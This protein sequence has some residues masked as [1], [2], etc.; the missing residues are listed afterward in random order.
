MADAEPKIIRDQQ[1]NSGLIDTG[2]WT[3]TRKGV[4]AKNNNNTPKYPAD[5]DHPNGPTVDGAT[6]KVS[7][8]HLKYYGAVVTSELGSI[9]RE[10]G[11]EGTII[12]D[13]NSLE[14][15]EV[16]DTSGNF[17]FLGA[18][19]AISNYGGYRLNNFA[20][21]NNTITYT[22]DTTNTG[23]IYGGALANM[24]DDDNIQQLNNN[25]DLVNTHPFKTQH[26]L[27][28][29]TFTSNTAS[30]TNANVIACGGA[31]ANLGYT[32]YVKDATFT[33][34]S[35]DLGGALYNDSTYILNLLGTFTFNGNTAT[36]GGAIYNTA[37]S[38]VQFQDTLTLQT[39]SDTIANYGALV[40]NLD[41]IDVTA[42]LNGYSYITNNGTLEILVDPT[43]SSSYTLATG[44]E[45]GE[46][47][48]ADAK[49]TFVLTGHNNER[50]DISIGETKKYGIYQYTLTLKDTDE[51]AGNNNAELVL[52][53]VCDSTFQVTSDNSPFEVTEKTLWENNTNGA[54][55][56]LESG[57]LKQ[58]L[59]STEVTFS[60]NSRANDNG[61][62]LFNSG[63]VTLTNATFVNNT[64]IDGPGGNAKWGGGAI[65]NNINATL[66]VSN[67]T[68]DNNKVT[69]GGNSAGGAVINWGN[70]TFE[71][72]TFTNQASDQNQKGSAVYNNTPYPTDY[73]AGNGQITFTECTFTGNNS[74]NGNGEGLVNDDGGY[75]VF[76]DCT[77]TNN[78]NCL[79][80]SSNGTIH[81]H[82]TNTFEGNTKN[83]LN[84]YGNSTDG[85]RLK[86][87]ILFDGVINLNT[88][89][90]ILHNQ[91]GYIF[92]DLSTT[93]HS[94][95]ING[96]K[97]VDNNKYAG[98]TETRWVAQHGLYIQLDSA[99]ANQEAKY[100]LGTDCETT[101]AESKQYYILTPGL[102]GDASNKT[103]SMNLQDGSVCLHA[104]DYDNAVF[105]AYQGGMARVVLNDDTHEL[106]LWTKKVSAF[107]V[108]NT[109]T[110]DSTE[111][112]RYA[113]APYEARVNT[114]LILFN[115]FAG[116]KA[117]ATHADDVVAVAGGTFDSDLYG[118]GVKLDFIGTATGTDVNTVRQVIAGS[119]NAASTSGNFLKVSKNLSATALIGGD[120]FLNTYTQSSALERN[121]VNDKITI[122]TDSSLN[123]TWLVGG[124]FLYSAD[125]GAN[126]YSFA[127][128][129]GAGSTITVAGEA[130]V[131]AKNVVGGSVVG[132]TSGKSFLTDDSTT[133]L[134]LNA[135]TYTKVYGAGYLQKSELAGLTK[136]G[137]VNITINGGTYT[138]IYGG[139][140]ASKL[141]YLSAATMTG[142]VNITVNA[143]SAISVVSIFGGN[144]GN[145]S[146]T[147]TTKA[148]ITFTGNGSNLTFSKDNGIIGGSHATDVETAKNLAGSNNSLVFAGFNG[149]FAAPNVQDFN[150][151]KVI[152][153]QQGTDP[154]VE[155][156]SAV[157]FTKE[158]DLKDVSDWTFESGCSLT[159]QNGTNDFTGDT[160]NF[161]GFSSLEV[162][163]SVAVFIGS[164][165]TLTGWDATTTSVNFDGVAAAD[166]SKFSL[167]SS[168]N[169]LFVTRLA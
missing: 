169:K 59:S 32:Q 58:D 70:A 165:D 160:L 158:L 44:V 82:G 123:T 109:W 49:K 116:A 41:G 23:K 60:G 89:L 19:A 67:S 7:G 18:G 6:L 14:A 98:I 42:T 10:D 92:W 149:N 121:N 84:N 24:Y 8:L 35:A 88:D 105:K 34:N 138:H 155:T 48:L 74:S 45:D 144:N 118:D 102:K 64:V 33:G 146:T 134:V 157:T 162:N 51:I 91:W 50:L 16:Q 1:F 103:L 15:L 13:N 85:Y 143:T 40:W 133:N 57:V 83:V 81:F 29:V 130:D 63:S 71:N 122:G 142:N 119:Q 159:W 110:A 112:V 65:S 55:H 77:F 76:T 151:V 140:G 27:E 12:F 135:G 107:F 21:T 26:R 94:A 62:A 93:D 69:I 153:L 79:A 39:S 115:G 137:D 87:Q 111:Q 136:T 66:V 139:I 22:G 127:D 108:N 150:A 166:Q 164:A 86:G 20:F 9:Y 168:D 120:K 113:G 31:F 145:G 132:G 53:L 43:M 5:E 147:K 128:G 3:V 95:T 156:G 152:N 167:T 163:Q 61:G 117:Q 96:Y 97:R 124:S 154:H 72:C 80:I 90:D 126:G 73:A 125:A 17:Y 78:S 75:M 25:G 47:T 101:L 99:T 46:G 38:T 28:N 114:D 56:V 4:D 100:V 37:G 104:D 30:S 131:T 36:E 52:T 148:T 129:T 54:I 11:T 106:E 68:F 141:S 2:T 161:N